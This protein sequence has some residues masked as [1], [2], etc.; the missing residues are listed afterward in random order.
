MMNTLNKIGVEG[1]HLNMIKAIS[2]KPSANITLNGKNPKAFH[3]K[4]GIGPG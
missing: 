3:L 4:C 1:E 2:D